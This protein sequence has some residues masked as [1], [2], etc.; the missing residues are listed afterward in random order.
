MRCVI[1]LARFICRQIGVSSRLEEEAITQ[2]K[3]IRISSDSARASCR[4]A[5]IFFLLV[6]GFTSRPERK[7][8]EAEQL[9]K[10]ADE[11]SFCAS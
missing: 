3:L 11:I 7:N 2:V 1:R 6:F 4:I 10:Q 8:V 5:K 9:Y